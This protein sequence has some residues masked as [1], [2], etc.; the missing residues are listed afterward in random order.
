MLTRY[1]KETELMEARNISA[2]CF[3]WSHDTNDKT[4]EDYA[5]HIKKNPHSKSD[6]YFNQTLAAFTDTGEMM[7][8]ISI[9]PYEVTFD[10]KVVPMSGI[11]GV[12]TYPQHRRKGA[13]RECFKH[14]LRDMYNN[15]SAFSYLYPFSEQFY[16]NF[17]YIPACTSIQWCLDLNTIPEYKS[18]GTF[19]LYRPFK[20]YTEFEAVYKDYAD[21]YNMMVHRDSYDWEV[22]KSADPFKGSRS[23]YLYKNAAG[24]AAGYL[25][26]E[27]KEDKD[28][29]ILECKELIF[30]GFESLKALMAFAKTFSADYDK[31]RFHA[32]VTLCL[33]YFC[34][35][36]SQSSSYRSFNQN[37]MVRAI[38]VHKLLEQA[39][40]QG[41]G[42]I[43]LQVY[44]SILPEND[45]IFTVT[46]TNG[47]ATQVISEASNTHTNEAD[48]YSAESLKKPD[49]EMTINQFS[50]AII[51]KY[52]ISDLEYQK[53]ITLN[54]SKEKA[55]SL[56]FKK[57]CWIHNPF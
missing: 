34:E 40:Y 52:Q 15:G 21:K 50:A 48:N 37:G 12:C 42:I 10:G 54:C 14:G 4:C 16:G 43:S 35:D 17:G 44:D 36:Y 57:P 41:S 7:S 27:R 25:I 32:P 51:G 9:L 49:L 13:V 6:A 46:F 33:D 1:I 18:K 47:K 20:D 38:N 29:V 24:K 23:A 30:D 39:N 55:A 56:I 2:L 19:S 28:A 22:L 53:G 3:N 45:R 31:I 26:F 8:C 5:D 11:G